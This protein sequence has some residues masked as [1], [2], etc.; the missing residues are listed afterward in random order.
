VIELVLAEHDDAAFLSLAQRIMNGAIAELRMSEVFLVQ[1]DNWFDHKW[2]GWCSRKEEELRVPP[3]TPNRVHSEKHFVWKS[4]TSTWEDIVLQK[5]LHVRQADRPRLAQ[6]LDCFSESAAFVWYSGNTTTNKVG[7]LM[8]YLSGA[9]GYSW[10]AS[11][12]K[13]EAWAVADECRITRRELSA[14]EERG[15]QLELAHT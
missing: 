4:E 13:S 7:S 11:F 10:Y 9:E 8:L 2:L 3:F 1:M 14:F 5:P 6:P 12:R 15:R